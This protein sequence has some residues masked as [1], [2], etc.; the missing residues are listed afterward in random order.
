M[1]DYH[2]GKA[3][4]IRLKLTSTPKKV[5]AFAGKARAILRR[6]TERGWDDLI[7]LSSRLFHTSSAVLTLEQILGRDRPYHPLR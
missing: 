7:S 6:G 5:A 2:D 4:F 1:I 3:L